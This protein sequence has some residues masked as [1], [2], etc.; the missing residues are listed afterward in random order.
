[1]DVRYDAPPLDTPATC[2]HKD[3]V[4]HLCSEVN[5]CAAIDAGPT[6]EANCIASPN[7]YWTDYASAGGNTFAQI[8]GMKFNTLATITN[9]LIVANKDECA[10]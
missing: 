5:I 10:D 9:A 8:E 6:A 7:C 3:Q 1:M 4:R 2:T